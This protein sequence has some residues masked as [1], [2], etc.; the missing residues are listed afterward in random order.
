[1]NDERMSRFIAWFYHELCIEKN[2]NRLR[3]KI[4]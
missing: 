4:R 3:K 1:M 2:L